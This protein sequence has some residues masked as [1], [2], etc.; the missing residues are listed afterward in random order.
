MGWRLSGSLI[1]ALIGRILVPASI[2]LLYCS[3]GRAVDAI[4]A[5]T[6]AGAAIVAV[7]TAKV[8]QQGQG[9]LI[10]ARELMQPTTP[11]RH[12]GSPVMGCCD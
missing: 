6:R 9:R 2:V 10:H 1:A 4:R 12:P 7:S 11:A 5:L 8:D 3:V